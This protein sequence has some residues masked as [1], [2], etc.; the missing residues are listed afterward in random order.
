MKSINEVIQGN[1]ETLQRRVA[2]N[3]ED[4]PALLKRWEASYNK[5]TDLDDK[6]DVTVKILLTSPLF[7]R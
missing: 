5:L 7:Y 1:E 3:L 6:I 2:A 4:Q